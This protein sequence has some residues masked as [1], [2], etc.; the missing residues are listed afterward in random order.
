MKEKNQNPYADV[1]VDRTPSFLIRYGIAVVILFIG[2]CIIAGYKVEIHTTHEKTEQSAV[3][4]SEDTVAGGAE[5]LS[6]YVFNTIM[7]LF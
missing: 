6:G 4:Q 5:T 2:I 7:S 3:Q 1:V